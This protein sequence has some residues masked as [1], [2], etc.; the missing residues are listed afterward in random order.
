MRIE[1]PGLPPVECSPNARVHWRDKALKAREY[2]EVVTMV[3][4]LERHREHWAAPEKA[5]VH[6]TFVL[7]DNRRRDRDNLIAR[8]KPLIDALGPF[9]SV[10]NRKGEVVSAY[11]CDIL[12][13]DDP[14]HAD[15]TYELV[16]EKGKSMTIVE[17]SSAG[18]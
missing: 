7:P 18:D 3:G 6:V 15:I 17:V 9:K 12:K 8:A 10:T 14:K 16:Y 2:K 5:T 11:G 13:D 1:I 4:N